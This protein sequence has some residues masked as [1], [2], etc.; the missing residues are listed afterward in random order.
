MSQAAR[1]PLDPKTM[2]PTAITPD[3]VT[4]CRFLAEH[5][6]TTLQPVYRVEVT[7]CDGMPAEITDV[8][9]P[10][11]TWKNV[12]AIFDDAI[13][14]ACLYATFRAARSAAREEQGSPC[15]HR[16]TRSVHWPEALPGGAAALLVCM[17]CGALMGADR[18]WQSRAQVK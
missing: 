8:R 9:R 11:E 5:A 14:S 4:G 16:A 1:L 17:D 6:T 18:Q 15:Q 10:P 13:R 2:K 12:S 7:F 3:M